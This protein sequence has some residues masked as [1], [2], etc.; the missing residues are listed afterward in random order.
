MKNEVRLALYKSLS[1]YIPSY[2]DYIVWSRWLTTWHG[3]ISN[4]DPNTDD[5][6]IIFAGVPF[7]LFT[8][9]EEEQK[10]ETK[11]IKLAKIKNATQ[12]NWAIQQ[13]HQAHNT[14]I[15]YI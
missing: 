14:V 13:H 10:K 4:Y 2:G 8:M 5:L 11:K 12:G 7:L 9:A 3:I 15:W 6:Y 1:D